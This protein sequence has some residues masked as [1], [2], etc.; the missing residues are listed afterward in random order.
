[1]SVNPDFRDV[2]LDPLRPAY[3]G[4]AVRAVV[5][6]AQAAD[7]LPVI[8]LVVADSKGLAED[9]SD[10]LCSLFW[11][12]TFAGFSEG[13]RSFICSVVGL[14]ERGGREDCEITDP[15]FAEHLNCSERTIIRKRRT[16]QAESQRLNFAVLV[17]DEGD[18]D[19]ATR[20]NKPTRYTVA[21]LASVVATV[22]RAR[23]SHLWERG[24]TRAAL[25]E[26]ARAEFTELTEAP[27]A[28]KK[29]KVKTRSVESEIES[30]KKTIK[31]LAA[32]LRDLEKLRPAGD[33]GR[34]WE[35]LKADLEK[36]VAEDEAAAPDSQAV[37]SAGDDPT[38][39]QPCH[40]VETEAAPASAAAG[41]VTVQL[42]EKSGDSAGG[43]PAGVPPDWSPP[44]EPGW[45]R[46]PPG[47]VLSEA[48]EEE[49]LRRQR[50]SVP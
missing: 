38:G 4:S 26:A 42:K 37:E 12:L 46:L 43:P 22:E 11:L 5:R 24:Q 19:Q 18:F 2:P 30:T 48:E 8:D 40:P 49:F 47:G 1:M 44:V 15:Q 31:T 23:G 13:V 34:L 29:R 20:K 45:L 14:I 50:G 35:A 32:K 33:V 16:Y 21:C 17:I 6:N 7:E 36:I 27:P 41:A 10:F 39:C 28:G 3:S 25:R 9:A